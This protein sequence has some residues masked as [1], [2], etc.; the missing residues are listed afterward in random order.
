MND[1]DREIALFRFQVI[2]PLLSLRG[3]KGTLRQAIQ[4][5]AEDFHH[6][7]YGGPTQY[8]F[9]TI[10]EWLYLYKSHGLDGLLPQR[11]KDKGKS[12]GID[13]EI[14]EKIESLILSHPVLTGP[15]ILSELRIQ[16]P[17]ERLPSLTTLYRFLKASGLDKRRVSP[18]VDHRAYAF[19]LA[20]DCWQADVMYGPAIPVP[21]GKRRKTYLI[22]IL[23]DATRLIPHA[24]FYFEQHLR[25]LKDC[26]KQ[27]FL[28]RGLPRRLYVDN[29]KIFR[30]RM[31]LALCARLGIQAIHSRPFRPQGR[32]KLERWFR[33]LRM[34]FLSRVDLPRLESLEQLNRLLWAWIEEEYHQRQHRGLEGETPLDRWLRLSEGIRSVPAEVDLEE[35]FLEETTRR[36]TKDGTLTLRGKTFEAGPL[37]IGERVAVHFDPFDLRRVLVVGAEGKKH[38]AYP[39]DLYSNRYVRRNPPREPRKPEKSAALKAMEDLLRKIEEKQPEEKKEPSEQKA[40]GEDQ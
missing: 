34:L 1:K 4:K 16:C 2:A 30:S 24:Q 8:A 36:V 7:P 28:K 17:P 23:D 29:G 13:G 21:D 26:L 20:G 32:A 37:L 14:A 39:V 10:E 12:R 25:S 27:S 3:P 19:E 6:H 15:G 22:G 40:A 35:V 18:H 11:R 33:T 9:A 31:I 38:P 5:I